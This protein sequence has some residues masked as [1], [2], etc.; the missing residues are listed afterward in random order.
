MERKL[1]TIQ[2]ISDIQSIPDADNIQVA[3]VRGWKVVV[4]KDEFKIGDRCVYC[5]IDSLMPE[6]NPHF[7]FLKNSKGKMQRIKTV[8]L[9][10]QISQGICFPISILDTVEPQSFNVGDNVTEC[11]GITKWELQIP[12][13][14]HVQIRGNRPEY[15]PKTDEERIQNIPAIVEELVGVPCYVSVKIDGTSASF[16]KLG[17]DIHVCS[18]NISK[19]EPEEGDTENVYWEMF[20][21]YNI[22]NVL[23]ELGDVVIQGEIAGPGIQKNRMGLK[24]PELFVFNIYEIQKGRYL[25]FDKFLFICNK[26]NLQTVPIIDILESSIVLNNE[27]WIWMNDDQYYNT[28][29][30]TFG[31]NMTVDKFLELAKGNYSNGYPRE[32][33]VIRPLEE[34][35]SKVLRGRMSFK[36]INNDYLLKGGNN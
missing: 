30:F 16:S 8:K 17:D 6:N 4:R 7:D 23:N 35:Y 28:A 3:S 15:I 34:T 1:A 18:R 25:D 26:Y 10:G 9:R 2:V 5:E 33:I 31:K 12:A 29:I 13:E 27:Y 14:L 20:K 32:G 11:L 24:S 22:E 21:K 36:I 19:K